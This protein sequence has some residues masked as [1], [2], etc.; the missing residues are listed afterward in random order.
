MACAK[1]S[2]SDAEAEAVRAVTMRSRRQQLLASRAARLGAR[3]PTRR[4]LLR[5]LGGGCAPRDAAS[6]HTRRV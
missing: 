1:A 4:R 5:A 2:G 6:S 3:L